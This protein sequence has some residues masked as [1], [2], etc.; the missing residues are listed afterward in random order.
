A[1]A[2]DPPGA[3]AR[4]VEIIGD[5][6]LERWKVTIDGKD[7]TPKG[8][9]KV[10]VRYGDTIT[11][12]VVAG[13]HGVAFAD[14]KQTMAGL[15]FQEGGGGLKEQPKFESAD[16]PAP[17]GTDPVTVKDGDPEKV[18]KVATVTNVAG[19]RLFTERGCLACHS[20]EGTHNASK[21]SN[22]PG[23]HS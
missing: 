3:K 6:N 13:R 7:A 15:D 11:W 9:A 17:W 2:V 5:G 21:S 18:L 10:T 1:L 4:K 22:Y 12:K 19:R 20:H 23:A 16:F 14:R 8:E